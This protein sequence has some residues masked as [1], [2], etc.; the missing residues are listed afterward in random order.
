MTATFPNHFVCQFSYLLLP[1]TPTAEVWNFSGSFQMRALRHGSSRVTCI[2]FANIAAFSA[3]SSF[4][5]VCHCVNKYRAYVTPLVYMTIMEL[6]AVSLIQAMLWIMRCDTCYTGCLE[7]CS[8]PVLCVR[9]DLC[10]LVKFVTAC[11]LVL[12]AFLVYF[13]K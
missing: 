9:V 13:K 1:S 6:F 7:H 2:S 11:I 8:R 3:D 10:R 5:I 12:S 4:R